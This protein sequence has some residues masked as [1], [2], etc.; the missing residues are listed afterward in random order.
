MYICFNLLATSVIWV[1]LGDFWKRT[2][3]FRAGFFYNPFA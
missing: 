3:L 2:N 1:S